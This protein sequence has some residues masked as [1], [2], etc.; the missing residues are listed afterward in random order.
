MA[1]SSPPG[2]QL[3][4]DQGDLLLAGAPQLAKKSAPKPLHA[5]HRARLRERFLKSPE[6]LP[7][8][9]LLEIILFPAR[10]VGDVKPLAKMLLAEFGSLSGVMHAGE[11]QLL[12]VPGANEAAVA[13]IKAV[14][15]A[16][17]RL[18]KAEATDRPVLQSWQAVLDYC[19]LKLAHQPHE[20]FHVL[21][22][23]R[24]F[25]LLADELQQKGTV[26]QAPVYP[27][28]VVKRALEL[29]AS[30]M[31]LIHNHPSGDTTP[32][33][34][35]IQITNQIVEAAKALSINVIDHIIIGRKQPYSFK[36]HGLMA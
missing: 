26:D 35:D 7:D 12:A 36:S 5:G 17:Q 32:S 8:Y 10:P 23:D 27:R 13:A 14:G 6:A 9:E 15:V 29:G 24:K 22:L 21:F 4:D 34:A 30:G 25:G 18:L 1:S 11:R 33:K 2:V 16:A 3:S 19:Q 31:I 20:E 28:E